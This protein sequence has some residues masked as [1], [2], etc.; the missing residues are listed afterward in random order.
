MH[1]L[2]LQ[3]AL[4]HWRR[5]HTACIAL[6]RNGHASWWLSGIGVFPAALHVH[7]CTRQPP[8]RRALP[9]RRPAPGQRAIRQGSDGVP[10]CGAHPQVLRLPDRAAASTV[11]APQGPSPCCPRPCGP[12]CDR[13]KFQTKFVEFRGAAE[14]CGAASTA[15]AVAAAA[16]V[17]ARSTAGSAQWRRGSL[18]PSTATSAGCSSGRTRHSRRLRRWSTGRHSDC[19]TG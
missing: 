2:L 17:E 7:V 1:C 12:I 9:P 10:A 15:A 14:H 5:P 19:W 18:L 11:V 8:G 13:L 4:R 3:L 6:L 16:A